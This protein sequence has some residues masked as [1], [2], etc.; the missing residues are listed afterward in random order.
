M[1]IFMLIYGILR[2]IYFSQ[3]IQIFRFLQKIKTHIKI[4]N[5]CHLIAAYIGDVHFT[6]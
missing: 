1:K 6:Y 2:N 3:E 4:N 5:N